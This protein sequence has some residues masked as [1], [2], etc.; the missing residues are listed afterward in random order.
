MADPWH[1]PSHGALDDTPWPETLIAR[2]VDRGSDDDRVNGYA[3]LG[4][5]ARN[6]DFT[7]LMYL[8]L[9]AELPTPAAS[10]QFK[11]AMVAAAP[12][13]VREASVHAGVLARLSGSPIASALGAGLVIA[14]DRARQLLD[15]H[16][17][18]LEW[19]AHPDGEA[20]AGFRSADD[21][22]WV[23]NL[24]GALRE[25]RPT[26]L[27]DDFTRDAARITLFHASGVTTSDRIQAALVAA[28]TVGV[29]SE[30]LATGPEHLAL[31]PV[32]MPPYRYVDD[33]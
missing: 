8:A 4:D 11:V 5:V 19:L 1:P 18:L 33:E 16:A 2:V 14:A 27:G 28:A 15:D 6:Y 30:A 3:V 20:P 22:M 29:A 12:V 32:K 23:A 9:T 10:Q 21:R 24:A 26:A 13:S 17:E 31:Y 25:F 7:D